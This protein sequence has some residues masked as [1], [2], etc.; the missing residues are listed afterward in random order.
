E[1]WKSVF[2]VQRFLSVTILC[3]DRYHSFTLI[4]IHEAAKRRRWPLSAPPTT[5]RASRR[6]D[7]P[8]AEGETADR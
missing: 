7:G 2:K 3:S 4:S 8:M 1:L 5:R 6:P